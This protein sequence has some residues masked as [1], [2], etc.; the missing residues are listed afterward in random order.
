LAVQELINIPEYWK[1]PVKPRGFGELCDMV[2]TQGRI[3]GIWCIE[4]WN[5]RTG[6]VKR[7]VINKNVVTDNGAV[8]ILASAIANA[9]NAN[10]WNNLYINNNSGSS[11][12]TTALTNGQ[13]G[14][15]SLALASLP[16]AIPLNN[17]SPATGATTV[18]VGYGT[19][20][21][22]QVTVNGA[23][24]AGA[25]ALTV[26]SYTSNAAYAIG[27]AVVPNPNVG[28]N[29]TNANLKVN[30]TGTV[31]EQYS[32]VI[33]SG[34]FTY[35]ATTG[36]GNRSVTVVFVFKNAT[37]GGSTANGNY[38]DCW[39]VNVTSAAANTTTGLFVGNYIAHEINTPMRVDNSNNVTATVVIKI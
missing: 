22:Q 13:T 38:T 5:P 2:E 8:N 14:I 3:T 10:P 7:R 12:L 24:A 9:S 18:T 36:A 23:A 17:I 37:N 16:A 19:G 27:A 35:S 31:V 33:A 28:E 25:V 39:L 20:Q 6:K 4:Q 32:G 15:V 1:N 34:G 26:S 30:Q 21:T 11:T 29:P